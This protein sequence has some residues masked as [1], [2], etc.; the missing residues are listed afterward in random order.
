MGALFG[1]EFFQEDEADIIEVISNE[2]IKLITADLNGE[3]LYKSL[4][5]IK[6]IPKLVLAV[7]SEAFG[8]SRKIS[9]MADYKI[10]IAHSTNVESL[11]AAVAGSIMMSSLYLSNED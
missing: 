6:N 11:N 7:G 10:S 1:L 4:K 9:D 3:E 2:K 5:K 8:L